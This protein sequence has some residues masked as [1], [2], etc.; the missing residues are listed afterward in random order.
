MPQIQLQRSHLSYQ[1]SGQGPDVL[2]IQGVGVIGQ[3]WRPQ[4]E[5]LQDRYR[6]AAFD[7]RG[8]G[9][10]PLGDGPLTIEAMA[11]DALALMDALGLQRAHVV[12]HSMG[13]VIAQQLALRAPQRVRSLAL[14][15][16]FARGRDGAR[17]PPRLLAQSLWAYVRGRAARRQAFL[18]LVTPEAVLR[19]GDPAALAREL[20]E[21]FGRDL[22]DQPSVVLKQL[23]AL[24]RSDLSGQLGPLASIPT[25]VVSA[26]EDRIARP[27]YGRALAAAIP[28]ARY[29]EIPGAGH[30]APIHHAAHINQ[31][32][33]QHFAA[34]A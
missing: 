6:L 10:S 7:N 31:L 12:G 4:I 23:R 29:V 14:L 18:E 22:A 17:L 30:A 32:L 34:A 5:A 24:A 28:A 3:G 25:L 21:L 33:A 20:G 16:T 11:G 9:D 13:G 26:A 15:C 27:A 1:I 8:I 19:R 2:L